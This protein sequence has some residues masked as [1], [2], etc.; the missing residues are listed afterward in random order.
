MSLFTII[1]PWRRLLRR[2]RYEA[3]RRWRYIITRHYAPP[4]LCAAPLPVTFIITHYYVTLT[5]TTRDAYCRAITLKLRRPRHM[6]REVIE[7]DI[8]YMAY[9]RRALCRQMPIARA[10]A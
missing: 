8:L 4:E 9:A 1:T 6:L 3:C 7:R 10:S 2:Q 5:V